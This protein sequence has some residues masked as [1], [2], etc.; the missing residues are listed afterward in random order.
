MLPFFICTSG[1]RE[2]MY[3]F[4]FFF[5][6]KTCIKQSVEQKERGSYAFN[7]VYLKMFRFLFIYDSPGYCRFVPRNSYCNRVIMLLVDSYSQYAHTEHSFNTLA[8]NSPWTCHIGV[9]VSSVKTFSQFT[10]DISQLLAEERPTLT[11]F[12][13]FD[14]QL[15]IG[16]FTF[17]GIFFLRERERDVNCLIINFI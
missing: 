4:A 14:Y 11:C 13:A 15:W 1:N 16:E 7:T 6:Q 10:L 5:S 9:W 12:P 17:P 2:T 8:F 3:L